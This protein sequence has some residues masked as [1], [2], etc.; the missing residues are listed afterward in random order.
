[1]MKEKYTAPLI[2]IEELSK[3]DILCNSTGDNQNMVLS[4]EEY[5]FFNYMAD[6]FS[7]NG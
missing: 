3:S 2:K 6:F 5:S 7:G 1:M 4:K